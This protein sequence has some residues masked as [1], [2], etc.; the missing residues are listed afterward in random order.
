MTVER[1]CL[2]ACLFNFY[3]QITYKV[4]GTF[5]FIININ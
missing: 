2:Y 5:S 1:L 3:V 4:F